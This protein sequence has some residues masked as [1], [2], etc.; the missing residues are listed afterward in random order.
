M[1]NKEICHYFEPTESTCIWPII[2]RPRDI[3]FKDKNKIS[4]LRHCYVSLHIH[5]YVYTVSLKDHWGRPKYL[6]AILK[7]FR[8]HDVARILVPHTTIHITVRLSFCIAFWVFLSWN[9]SSNDQGNRYQGYLIDNWKS[10]SF[11]QY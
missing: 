4:C 8:I 10:I 2:L 7:H 6:S 5:D 3:M 1:S 9:L 11:I